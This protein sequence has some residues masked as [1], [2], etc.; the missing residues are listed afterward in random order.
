MQ[1]TVDLTVIAN[2]DI[3]GG[4]FGTKSTMACTELTRRHSYC[5]SRS[6][7]LWRFDFGW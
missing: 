1:G 3:I 4:V 5:H 2:Y 6:Y 7:F